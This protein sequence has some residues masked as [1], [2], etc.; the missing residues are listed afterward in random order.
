LL[1]RNANTAANRALS[2]GYDFARTD[3]VPQYVLDR[4]LWYSVHGTSSQP[5]PPGPNAALGR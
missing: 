5:P 2:R 1:Q 4:I 3:E